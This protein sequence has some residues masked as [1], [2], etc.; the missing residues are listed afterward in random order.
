MKHLVL[1]S[2][3]VL[4]G[5]LAADSQA[6]HRRGGSC[7]ESD[8][9]PAC[10]SVAPQYVERQVTRYKCVQTEREVQQVVSRLV[11]REEQFTYTVMVPV[12]TQEVRK[13]TCYKPV[14]REV[15]YTCNVL[16]PVTTN[17]KRTITECRMV[18]KEVEAQVTVMVPETVQQTRT[19]TYCELERREQQVTVPVCRTVQEQCTDNCG[20]C[21]TC[22]KRVME[23]QTVTRVVCVPVTKTRE[24]TCNVTVCKPQQQTV[25]RIICEPVTSTREI[26]VP[27][28]RCETQQ[29]TLKRTICE[30]V[31]ETRDVTVNV[32]TC[33][34]EQRTGTRTVYDCKRETVTRKVLCNEMVPYTETIKVP[35]CNTCCH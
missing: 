35:V 16:V 18:R 32:T 12:T 34:A 15:D 7:C 3:V 13:Q 19:V 2:A 28:T 4:M 5:W 1:T 20:N 9:A 14:T 24:V 6:G 11:P 22:C 26:T 23:E 30:M 10:E 31:P 21:Y 17:E 25:K 29:R 8:C 33:K 27:V